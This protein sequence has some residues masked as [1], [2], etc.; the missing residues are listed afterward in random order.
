M[1][2]RV[3]LPTETQEELYRVHEDCKKEALQEFV[4]SSFKDDDQRYQNELLS[5]INDEYKKKCTDNRD[6]SMKHCTDLLNRIF[7]CLAP[8]CFIRKGGYQAYKA[9]QNALIQ[10]YRKLPGRGIEAEHALEAFLGN[11]NYFE[12]LILQADTCL[13]EKEE[14][15]EGEKQQT[16]DMIVRSFLQ[17]VK[18]MSGASKDDT[19]SR[20]VTISISNKCEN[21]HLKEPRGV[22][23]MWG[24]QGTSHAYR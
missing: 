14:K 9:K 13:T 12:D 23:D 17:A 11:N 19:S 2:Q 1:S 18:Q 10:E 16:K 6:L 8:G 5:H 15:A 21:L 20:N 7:G 3:K 24:K 4:A 22:C